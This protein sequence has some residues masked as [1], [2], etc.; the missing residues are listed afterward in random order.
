MID[1]VIIILH[2]MLCIAKAVGVGFLGMTSKTKLGERV[3][4]EPSRIDTYITA[5]TVYST[6]PEWC[7]CRHD[8]RRAIWKLSIPVEPLSLL[9]GCLS[10]GRRDVSAKTQER[11]RGMGSVKEKTVHKP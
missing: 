8:E 4:S 3:P 10:G 1:N 6:T 9:V 5:D 7:I 11:S 2:P